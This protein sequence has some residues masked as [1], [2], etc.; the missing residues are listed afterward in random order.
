MLRKQASNERVSGRGR[1]RDAWQGESNE[2]SGIV[3]LSCPTWCSW[4]LARGRFCFLF[5]LARCCPRVLVY[6]LLLLL[7]VCVRI[8]PRR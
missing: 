6:L 5:L 4:S 7:R 8:P 2:L 1:R 3:A